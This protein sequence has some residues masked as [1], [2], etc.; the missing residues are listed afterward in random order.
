[1]VKPSF[2]S[3][4]KYLLHD[5]EGKTIWKQP[6]TKTEKSWEV[7]TSACSVLFRKK[8]TCAP[9]LLSSQENLSTTSVRDNSSP[10]TML[11]FF[12]LIRPVFLQCYQWHIRIISSPKW[13]SSYT[14]FLW[15]L[16][17]LH[18]VISWIFT[19]ANLKKQVLNY[20]PMCRRQRFLDL[21]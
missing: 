20:E 6:L 10:V 9:E 7:F 17:S 15:R 19:L 5:L 12:W 16:Q 18:F 11:Y 13:T 21:I 4:W 1:M 14:I 3:T 8:Q 2:F